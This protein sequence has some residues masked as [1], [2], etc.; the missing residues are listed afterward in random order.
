MATMASD[1]TAT[2]TTATNGAPIRVLVVDDAVAVRRLMTMLFQSEP[3]LEL[4]GI[5]QDGLV[6]LEKIG[7]LKPDIISLDLAMPNMD[8]LTM[9]REMRE[10]GIDVPVI[11]FSTLTH[12]GAKETIEGLALGAADYVTKPTHYD[13]PMDALEAVR[14]ELVPRI[15]AIVRAAQ[16]QPEAAPAA[17]APKG[18]AAGAGATAGQR[19]GK[20]EAIVIGSSTGG[21]NALAEVISR[22]PGNL[23]VPVLVAQH[24]PPVYTTYLAQRLDSLSSLTV[25]EA[26]D[27]EPVL[28]GTVYIAPGDHH[29]TL[30]PTASGATIALTQGAPVNHCRPSVDVLFRSAAATYGKQCLAIV[31]TGMG[32]D[33]RDGAVE[34]HGLGAQILIQDEATSVVWGMPGA[35]HETGVADEVLPVDKIAAAAVRLTA[36]GSGFRRSG[37]STASSASPAASPAVGGADGAD[38]PRKVPTAVPS[39]VTTG[40]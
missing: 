5:A 2:N 22:L 23:R 30:R 17:P 29:L 19:S 16:R 38:V 4:A 27:G 34:L 15:K 33:G 40:G 35:V 14:A 1:T 25:R 32:H 37:P 9:L 36:V 11:M 18:A 26:V 6:A 21:P 24:M 7:L 39:S 12:H 10:R 3:D 28:A 8:G 13:N 20:V 31:L